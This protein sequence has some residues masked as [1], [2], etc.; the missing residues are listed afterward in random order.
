MTEEELKV[1]I[2]NTT[3]PDKLKHTLIE[4][5]SWYDEWQNLDLSEILQDNE[6]ELSE[7]IYNIIIHP[8]E[9]S[10]LF[11]LNKH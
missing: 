3:L 8:E 1:A 7:C 11:N 10:V 6:F 4:M 5:V 9:K 2:L